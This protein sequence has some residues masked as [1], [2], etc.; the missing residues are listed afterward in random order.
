[1]KIELDMSTF[2][3]KD[4]LVVR[5]NNISMVILMLSWKINTNYDNRMKDILDVFVGLM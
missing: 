5:W 1:M 3:I 4:V 2:E